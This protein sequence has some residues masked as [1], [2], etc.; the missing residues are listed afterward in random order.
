ML[1]RSARGGVARVVPLSLEHVVHETHRGGEVEQEVADAR[2]RGARQEEPVGPGHRRDHPGVE[3]A[4]E[5]E[6]ASV[7]SLEGV[8]E[9]RRLLV[10]VDVEVWPVVWNDYVTFRATSLAVLDMDARAV[11]AGALPA[12]ALAQLQTTFES[13]EASGAFFASAAIM[14]ARGRKSASRDV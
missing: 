7:Q 3:L 12:P 13:A 11:R 9:A 4:V 1:F 2:L 5:G 14:I 10:D 6:H 8:G